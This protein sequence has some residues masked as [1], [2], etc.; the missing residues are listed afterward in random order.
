MEGRTDARTDG[1]T[2]GHGQRLM[3]FH[4]LR[5]AWAYWDKIAG[6]VALTRYLMSISSQSTYL[7]DGRT[8]GRT[9]ARTDGR[10]DGRTWATLNALPHS[11]NSGGIK[12]HQQM[13]QNHEKLPSTKITKSL[14]P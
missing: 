4:I 3:P 12:N 8:E 2:D 1:R 11:T 14:K 9:D 7:N 10:T 13:T 5:I 6:G